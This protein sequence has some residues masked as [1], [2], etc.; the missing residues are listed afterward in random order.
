MADVNN[1]I[2]LF[3]PGFMTI[4]YFQIEFVRCALKTNTLYVDFDVIARVH[5]IIK[6]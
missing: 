2:R 5:D 3:L 6:L 1:T 4:G